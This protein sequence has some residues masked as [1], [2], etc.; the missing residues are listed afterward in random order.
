[1]H[2]KHILLLSYPTPLAGVPTVSADGLYPP[3]RYAREAALVFYD[4]GLPGYAA[5]SNRAARLSDR[6]D[7]IHYAN[8][9]RGR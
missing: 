1:M 7:I 5:N 4:H 6:P 3:S 2:L 9:G 8:T